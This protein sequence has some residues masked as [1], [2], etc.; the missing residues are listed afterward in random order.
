M[1][2]RLINATPYAYALAVLL[3]FCLV[4]L[5]VPDSFLPISLLL[6]F[7][8]RWIVVLPALPL[9]LLARSLI[10]RVMILGAASFGFFWLADFNTNLASALFYRDEGV[11][12]REM[13]DAMQ[14]RVASH[15][16]AGVPADTTIAFYLSYSLDALLL[17]ETNFHEINAFLKE[18]RLTDLSLHCAGRL[19][20]LTRWSVETLAKL[21]RKPPEEGWGNYA[22]LFRLN[23]DVGDVLL[24]NV[25]F[26]TPR[27]SLELLPAFVTHKAEIARRN[28][29]RERQSAQARRWYEA[30]G[31][32]V[33]YGGDFNLTEASAIYRKHWADLKNAFGSAGWGFGYTKKGKILFS[34]RIDHLL[35][36]KQV[37]ATWAVVVPSERGDH[38]AVL[39]IIAF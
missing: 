35:V 15:N 36:P 27:E 20:V 23:H 13:N 9:M 6:D 12:S 39:T 11:A 4:A 2:H 1:H 22:A 21:V 30:Y 24:A 33:I 7:G 8:P 5:P 10:G 14:F 25:H 34:A 3:W 32:V 17:Q 26:N 16:V 19:C 38:H 37:P 31:G 29:I 18:E 28:L